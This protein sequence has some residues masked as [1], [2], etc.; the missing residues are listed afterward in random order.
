MEIDQYY[1]PACPEC[2]SD[3]YIVVDKLALVEDKWINV[4]ICHLCHVRFTE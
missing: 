4:Y 3:R 2:K 1:K